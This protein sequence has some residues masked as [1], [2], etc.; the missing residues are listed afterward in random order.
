MIDLGRVTESTKGGGENLVGG[1][2]RHTQ[3]CRIGPA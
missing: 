2:G 3:R 1:P